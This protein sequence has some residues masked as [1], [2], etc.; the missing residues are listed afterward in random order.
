MCVLV[1]EG[2]APFKQR[3]ML[4]GIQNDFILIRAVLA[5]ELKL[6]SQ[7]DSESIKV[8]ELAWSVLVSAPLKQEIC[9]FSINVL[10]HTGL[11]I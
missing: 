9:R 3:P 5:K 2:A 11:F 8:S 4:L 7:P 1:N 10:A 6:G